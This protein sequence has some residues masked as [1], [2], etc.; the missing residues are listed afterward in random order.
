MRLIPI[1]LFLVAC[2]DPNSVIVTLEPNV[3]SSIDG[4]LSVRALVTTDQ[5]PS[6]DESVQITI[7]YTD[8]NGMIHDVAPI[9]GSTNANGVFEGSISG[10]NWDG[11]GTVTAAVAD[12]EGKAT[13][14]VLDRTPPKVTISP[15]ATTVRVGGNLRVMVAATDEIGISQLMFE[16]GDGQ[17]IQRDRS[18]IV[19]GS[20]D[21]TASFEFQADNVTA[22][23]TI[24]LHALAADLSGNL[25]AA[26]VVTVMVTP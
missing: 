20:T 16:A 11:I 6:V 26:P 17:Q 19:S 8:R 23:Q 15:Q 24:S 12:I 22:G 7:A 3:V 18:T 1:L 13:F 2:S 10:L 14:S 5:N 25:G 21:T 9:S 4:T